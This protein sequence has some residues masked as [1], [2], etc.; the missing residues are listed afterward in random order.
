[1]TSYEQFESLAASANVVPLVETM[2]ADMHTPVST[3]M[4]LRD[5]GAPS[6]LV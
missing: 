6:F 1:M 3:Y 4:T 5:G 2:L